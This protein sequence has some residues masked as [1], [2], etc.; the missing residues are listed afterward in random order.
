MAALRRLLRL[1][2]SDVARLAA[3]LALSVAATLAGA[4]L[5]AVSGWFIA[6][7]AI[8]GAAG[9]TMNYFTPAALIRFLAIARSGGRY[10]ERVL[11]HDATL[12][13]LAR[14]RVWLFARLVPLAPAALDDLRSGDVL[15]RLKSDV[16][17]LELVF[18]RLISP[19]VAAAA[20]LAALAIVLLTFDAG[21]ALAVTAT[22]VVFGLIAPALAAISGRRAAARAAQSGA[23]LKAD[24][25]EFAQGLAPLLAV[26]AQEWRVARSRRLQQ[27]QIAA[28]RAERKAAAAGQAC[29]G[30]AGDLALVVALALAVP[31]LRDGVLSGPYL[32]AAA[33][34]AQAAAEALTPLPLALSQ[35]P[36][37][38][39]SAARVFA[40]VD[41]A[42][43]VVDPATP[44]AAPAR[45]D[46]ALRD[47][48]FAYGQ[49]RVLD[50]AALSLAPG[51]K[52]A[53]VGASGAGKSTLVDLMLRFRDPDSGDVLIGGAPAPACSLDAVRAH[54]AVAPQRPHLFSATLTE[55]L[56]VAAP[57]ATDAA[58]VAAVERAGLA[59]FLARSPEGL[60][61]QLG[62]A[63]ARL[64]GGEARRVALARAFLSA[65]PI[66]VLDEPG[67]G[68]DARTEQQTIAAALDDGR[69]QSVVLLTHRRAGLARVARVLEL[70]EGRLV[71]RA[72]RR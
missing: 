31:L 72:P 43:L 41:R 1:Y 37:T 25:V 29:A 26:N 3:T 18:L 9:T 21:I 70:H 71:S 52:V 68:L 34:V 44:L 50:G 47:L 24:L 33:L 65:A 49:T 23:R 51:E 8:A 32:V 22:L 53:I 40:L 57:D 5:I 16:D 10:A 61:T 28:E 62:V 48:H 60:A 15:A 12:R 11:G 20:T 45:G 35:L 46:M 64:S 59:G 69:G 55:N 7:M 42:P 14:L 66:L 58:L 54:F 19:G 36:A 2:R 63:G 38:L 17:R 39:A 4:A 30:L 67:E 13:L 6:A 56:R 27:D